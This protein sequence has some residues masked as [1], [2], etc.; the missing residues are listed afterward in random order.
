MLTLKQPATYGYRSVHDLPTPPSTSRPSPPLSHT[1]AL[2]Y[3][4]P[5]TSPRSHS[6]TSSI[7][8]MSTPHRGLPPPAAMALPPQQASSSGVPSTPHPGHHQQQQQQQ[9]QQ[10]PPPPPQQ[11]PRPQHPQGHEPSVVHGQPWTSL[12]PP[13]Q[14]W[15]G[16]E[17]AMKNWLQARTEEERTKQEEEKTRQESLRLEQRRV[18]M[19]MLR[20]SMRFGVPPHM[21]PLVFTGM[22][23]AGPSPQAAI[24]WSQQFSPSSQSQHL[25]QHSPDVQQREGHAHS[26]GTYPSG[27]SHHQQQQQQQQ[28]PP[29]P[30]PP[31]PPA[32]SGPVTYGSY[33][34]S[35]SR[36]RGQ[37]VGGI[38]GRAG[39]GGGNVP[40]HAGHGQPGGPMA[41]PAYGGGSHSAHMHAPSAPPQESSPSLYFHH[42]QPPA[43]QSGSGSSIRSGSP[44]GDVI[45][46]R[47]GT[48]PQPSETP[49]EQRPR[50]P[51]PFI[52]STL[53]N[54][55]PARKGGGGH[56][57]Q[58]SD[59]SWYRSAGFHT[60]EE[61]ERT[62]PPPSPLQGITP[63]RDVKAEFPRQERYAREPSRQSVSTLLSHDASAQPAREACITPARDV[64][65]E[66][67]R[68]ERYAGESSRHSVSTLLSHDASGQPARE[69]SSRSHFPSAHEDDRQIP[70]HREEVG[71]RADRASPRRESN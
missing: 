56:K 1:E 55:P 46:K 12:P 21:I 6:P 29:P 26:Q 47:K 15:H 7:Q 11:H 19:G 14:Q 67:P 25:R 61:P 8:T 23:S 52:Q 38:V 65:A 5:T 9:Q 51:P 13:P 35:P 57:R 20:D 28:P 66:F 36:Q 33:P 31:P 22:S 43:T 59:V 64:K 70:R 68:Q 27:P 3:L 16:A 17:D 45:R 2:Y 58:K 24:E 40:P 54:P 32:P 42:W 63:A 50:S 34:A 18:E 53:S 48:G 30:P 69:A 44:S 41:V 39:G 37:T 62:P 4:H 49:G 10:Q 60:M 71:L